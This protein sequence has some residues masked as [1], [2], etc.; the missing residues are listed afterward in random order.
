MAKSCL[1]V[2]DSAV[3]RR[4]VREI[5]EGFGFSCREAE[6]GAVACDSCA[7]E[8]PGLITLDWNMPVMN[9]L[10]FLQKLRTME[11]GQAP[12]VLFCTTEHEMSFI[13]KALEAGATDFIMKPFD[14]EIMRTKLVQNN[15]IEDQV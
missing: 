12:A 13:Q 7:G 4:I 6:N 5:M 10:E 9:G 1:I 11:G 8:M 3:I 2:D 14:H 15:L